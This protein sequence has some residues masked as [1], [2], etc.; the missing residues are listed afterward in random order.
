M[1]N[2]IK[3][4]IIEDED[5]ISNF[6][7]TTLKANTYA[8]LERLKVLYEEA[9]SHPSVVGLVIGTR[10]DCMPTELLDYLT[11]LNRNT[12]L[13]VEYGVESANEETLLRINRGHSF[14]TAQ[15]AI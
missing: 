9:L 2:K 15:R 12:F 11:E 6:V 5:A 4:M 13:L 10:P 14:A 3:I 8:P 7:A 1:L